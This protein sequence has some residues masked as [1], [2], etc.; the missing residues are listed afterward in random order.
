MVA[1]N[2]DASGVSPELGFETLPAGWY[3]AMIDESDVKPTKDGAG[4]YLQLRFSILDGWAAGRKVF[5]RLN[6]RNSNATTQ[7]IA[8]KALSAIAHAVNIL[9]VQDS[10]QLHGIPLNIKLKVRKDKDG[11]YDDQNDIAQV[12]NI[13]EPVELVGPPS[14]ASAVG[15]FPNN[16]APAM[17]QGFPGY[18]AP[19]M[20]A[21]QPAF[22][23][24][25]GQAAPYAPAAQ[26][27]PPNAMGFAPNAGNVPAA[28]G[29]VAAA[30]PAPMP[31]Q[32]PAQQ[33]P[34]QAPMQQAPVQGWQPPQAQQPW[35]A[36][37]QAPAQTQAPVQQQQPAPAQTQAP[38]QAPQ[39]FNP[40]SALPPWQQ[41]QQ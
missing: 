25:P 19:A 27:M 28:V 40:A 36:P 16:G 39:G 17:P 1:L 32:A 8:L 2:F 29:G 35:Q 23:G 41:P 21:Q 33:A 7:E 24:Q 31:W 13:N 30:S 12:K 18:G 5:I 4:A 3:R 34:A 20:P 15:A 9:H 10:A 11:Q 6:I 14:V 26:G 38:A 37:A 22:A